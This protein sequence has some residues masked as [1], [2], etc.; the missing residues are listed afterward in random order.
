MVKR[1]APSPVVSGIGSSTA[2]PHPQVTA[3]SVATAVGIGSGRTALGV[4][5]TLPETWLEALTARQTNLTIVTQFYPPDFAATGQ[6]IE[7]LSHNLVHENLNVH[8]FTG[9]PGYAYKKGDAPS[10]ER[11][12]RLFVQRSRTSRLLQGRIRGKALNGVLFLIRA[13]VHMLKAR[14]RGD[15]LMVTTAP[16][17]LVVL[18]YLVHLLFRTP[19]ICLLYDL[20]PDIAVE[21]GVVTAK[22]PIARL[23]D[24]FNRHVWRKSA[25]LIVLSSTMRDRIVAKCPDVASKIAVIHS[26]ADPER[27]TPMEKA[28]NWFAQQHELVE[29]FT[30]VYS[31]NMGRCH[32]M[33]TILQAAK[34]LA[35]RPNPNRPIKFVFIGDGAKRKP[36]MRQI[37][38]WGLTNC[39]FLPYQEKQNLSYSLT[40]SDLSLVSVSP[41]MEGLV[42]PSKLYS[43]LA[44]GRPLAIIC[45]THSYLR[46]LIR[47]ARCGGTFSS[48]DSTALADFILQLS[49][50]P[51][52]VQDMG[53]A[54]RSYM[55]A[56]FTPTLIA[57]EYAEVMRAAIADKVANRSDQVAPFSMPQEKNLSADRNFLLR[58]QLE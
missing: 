22:H 1:T 32:D 43:A 28:D 15:V 27:I 13:L 40:A 25:G 35:H 8:V 30:V 37:E 18:G 17:F 21:L 33:D 19:Y 16:P 41:G 39:T 34:M 44:A 3:N 24:K 20:Y 47:D 36:A 10:K 4:T 55:E 29:P 26:W 31:G 45:E 9:Q 54:G 48:G 2:L 56:N 49:E 11:S 46:D 51:E 14:H 7:E 5:E 6:L 53:N 38:E 57:Q 58:S 12:E 42:A 23:W 52:L 50:Q